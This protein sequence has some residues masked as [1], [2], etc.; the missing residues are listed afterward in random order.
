MITWST[1]AANGWVMVSHATR[2]ETARNEAAAILVA[3]GDGAVAPSVAMRRFAPRC[4][5]RCVRHPRRLSRASHRAGRH[6]AVVLVQ[7]LA[8]V[9]PPRSDAGPQ[10]QQA[11]DAHDDR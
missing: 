10:R 4:R 9:A 6:P 11:Q 5:L 2:A 7:A 3:M 8:R 1:R